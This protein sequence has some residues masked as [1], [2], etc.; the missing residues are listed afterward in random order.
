VQLTAP[1]IGAPT[2][3]NNNAAPEPP[4]ITRDEVLE[5]IVQNP[6]VAKRLKELEEDQRQAEE[7]MRL[8][9][10]QEEIRGKIED[11]ENNE[12]A[13]LANYLFSKKRDPSSWLFFKALGQERDELLIPIS[14]FPGRTEAWAS[15]D[16]ATYKVILLGDANVGKTTIVNILD[17]YFYRV[18]TE[19]EQ[20]TLLENASLFKEKRRSMVRNAAARLAQT[21]ATVIADH[22][23]L[24]LIYQRRIAAKLQVWDTAGQERFAAFSKSYTRELN[25]VI[26]VFSYGLLKSLDSV[27]RWIKVALEGGLVDGDDS[28]RAASLTWIVIGNKYDEVLKAPDPEQYER[29]FSDLL[30]DIY[31]QCPYI[32]ADRV[33]KSQASIGDVPCDEIAIQM[34]QS[35]VVKDVR[36]NSNQQQLAA[37]TKRRKDDVARLAQLSIRG[38]LLSPSNNNNN[39]GFISLSEP[40]AQVKEQMA[41]KTCC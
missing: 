19:R 27:R 14:Y 20:Q 11:H 2:S 12:R 4:G 5:R 3:N 17:L 7:A 1:G 38:T 39:K 26:V 40:S 35:L 10:K 32:T 6:A 9:R 25:A 21:G 31:R 36:N 18:E 34:M 28:A 23:I 13:E 22:K 16:Q 41:S 8:E 33:F 15:L 29:P 30:S 24:R 37:T